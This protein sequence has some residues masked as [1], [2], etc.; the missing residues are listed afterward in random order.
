MGQLRM[1]RGRAGAVGGVQRDGDT[2]FPAQA[3]TGSWR[4]HL[5]DAAGRLALDFDVM[6]ETDVREIIVRPL[7]H[8]LGYSHGSEA[9]I[10]TEVSLKYPSAFLGRKKPGKDPT[11]AGRADYICEVISYGRW[12]VE[13]K[14]PSEVLTK[15][16]V[17]QAHTYAAHPEIGAAFILVTNGRRFE[18]YRT[19]ALDT[20][21]LAFGHDQLEQFLLPLFNVVGPD[22][23]K[24]LSNLVRVDAG[25]PLGRNLASALAITGGQITYEEHASDTPL[26]PRETIEGL[27][28][29]VVGGKVE[30]LQ[31]GRIHAYVEIGKAAAIFRDLSE[32]MGAA[33]DYDFYSADE[34]ISTDPEAPTIFQNLYENTTPV[35]TRTRVPGLGEIALP[36]GMVVKAYT[37]AVGYVDAGAFRG[38]MRLDY[39]LAITSLSP[40]VR[41]LLEAQLG[42]KIPERS[43]FSGVGSFEVR[44]SD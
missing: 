26:V 31:D 22:A 9:N 15:E 33:D 7:L 34:Y 37:Q 2:A 27:Q 5:T 11:L 42:G 12:V 8:R 25:K 23:I 13:V 38:T 6:N 41:P 1:V 10:R 43:A 21:L 19:G 20:S 36:F 14:P 44:L 32:M 3:H 29:P 30:R 18:L 16:A 24:K 17:Q 40:M 28:L 35:G 39:E 4:R